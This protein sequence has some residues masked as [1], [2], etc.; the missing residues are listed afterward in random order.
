VSKTVRSA[1]WLLSAD[2]N[3]C[4]KLLE[5]TIKTILYDFGQPLV[6]YITISYN[7]SN[8]FFVTMLCPQRE[9]KSALICRIFASFKRF[10]YTVRVDHVESVDR[11]RVK[12]ISN[13][14][15]SAAG[16]VWCRHGRRFGRCR[17]GQKG[18]LAMFVL[19]G[20]ITCVLLSA[21]VQCSQRNHIHLPHINYIPTLTPIGPRQ[22]TL[23][24]ER[25]AQSK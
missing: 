25:P 13:R 11:T 23:E 21:V 1:L 5:Y 10:P 18:Q 7:S 3:E 8:L 24:L 2:D 9:H 6:N 15:M 14:I 22:N 12:L 20:H 4:A 16:D 19:A 17:H